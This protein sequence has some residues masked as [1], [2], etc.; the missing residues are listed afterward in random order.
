MYGLVHCIVATLS[1]CHATT[2]PL[3]ENYYYCCRYCYYYCCCCCY[4]DYSYCYYYYTTLNRC[5]SMGKHFVVF[6]NE[7]TFGV[8]KHVNLLSSVRLP[9]ARYAASVRPLQASL[10]HPRLLRTPAQ[11]LSLRTRRVGIFVSRSR[12]WTDFLQ[13]SYK[14]SEYPSH[15]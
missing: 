13:P 7:M 11:G 12:L 8:S 14:T 1:T 10:S 15:F 5:Q 6:F 3:A 9:R 4:C 2:F